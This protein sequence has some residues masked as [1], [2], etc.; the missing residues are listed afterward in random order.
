MWLY[1]RLPSAANLEGDQCFGS[2]CRGGNGTSYYLLIYDGMSTFLSDQEN[3]LTI[4][5]IN[6]STLQVKSIG[7]LMLSTEC[8]YGRLYPSGVLSYMT[9][10]VQ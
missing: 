8:I 10:L 1:Y 5:E 7:Y 6:S 9:K 2:C 4:Q 3:V